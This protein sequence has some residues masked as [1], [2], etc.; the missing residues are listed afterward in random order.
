MKSLSFAT[1]A[2][3]QSAEPEAETR[4]QRRQR[5]GAHALCPSATTVAHGRVLN[6]TR[7]RSSSLQHAVRCTRLRAARPNPS[8]KRSANGRPPGPGWWYAVHFHQPGPS[9]LPLSPA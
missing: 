1:P 9:V 3:R 4:N 7:P 6:R 5:Q 2:L 8:L